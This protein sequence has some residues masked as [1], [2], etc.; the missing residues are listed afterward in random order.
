MS[1]FA[2]LPGE[3]ESGLATLEKKLQL[4]RDLIT[5]VGKR[6][7]NVLFVYGD[8][9]IGKSFQ[10]TGHPEELQVPYKLRNSRMSARGP[11]LSLQ[12]V[13]DAVHVLEDMGRIIKN[14][15]AP[16]PICPS[17]VPCPIPSSE[18]WEVLNVRLFTARTSHATT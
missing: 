15:N 2:V 9:G 8:G 12:Q 1:D 18:I 17:C 14:P 10:A 7:K 16:W 13:P 6:Y 5:A 4:Y 11:F 3:D